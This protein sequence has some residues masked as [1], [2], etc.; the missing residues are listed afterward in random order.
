MAYCCEVCGDAF[1]LP[2]LTRCSRCER[3]CCEACAGETDYATDTGS[4]AVCTECAKPPRCRYCHR[5]ALYRTPPL[6]ACG[7]CFQAH[8]AEIDAE[9]RA[10]D[11]EQPLAD[12]VRILR[13]GPTPDEVREL[14][15]LA[16][17]VVDRLRPGSYAHEAA[18]KLHGR[19]WLL[20]LR[21]ERA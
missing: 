21:A 10:S 17:V 5:P 20:R 4:T 16:R 11:L 15:E 14:H 2:V 1:L 19:L 18:S 7:P 12:S 9:L 3:L 13:D 6:N 8:H